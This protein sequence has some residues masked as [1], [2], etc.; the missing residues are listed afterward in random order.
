MKK[1]IAIVV[2]AAISVFSI[3]YAS[4]QKQLANDYE[5]RAAKSEQLVKELTSRAEQARI[6]ANHAQIEMMHQ[7][8]LVQAQLTELKGKK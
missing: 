8:E 2:M 3:L 1:N 5:S 6:M 4:R 7:R